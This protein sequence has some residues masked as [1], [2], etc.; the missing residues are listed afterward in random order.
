[1][2]RYTLIGTTKS[3]QDEDGSEGVVVD[4]KGNEGV[5]SA[6]ELIFARD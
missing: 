4:T 2:T 1:M 5:G 6:T 3:L